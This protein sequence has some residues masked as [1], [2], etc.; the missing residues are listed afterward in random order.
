[1]SK[2]SSC[3]GQDIQPDAAEEKLSVL[4]SRG[5]EAIKPRQGQAAEHTCGPWQAAKH[6]CGLPRVHEALPYL[7]GATETDHPWRVDNKLEDAG[8]P[9]SALD[10]VQA[11]VLR[12]HLQAGGV[13]L[14]D[15]VQGAKSLISSVQQHLKGA[16]G[17]T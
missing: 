7:Q 6:T 13:V 11:A 9:I 2:G 14:H 4:D 3:F 15:G 10:N 17:L 8:A 12:D 5:L 1:M 16:I